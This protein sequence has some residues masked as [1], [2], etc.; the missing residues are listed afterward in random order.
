VE[1]QEQAENQQSLKGDIAYIAKTLL[2]VFG[3]FIVLPVAILVTMLA[4][5]PFPLNYLVVYSLLILIG[6]IIIIFAARIFRSYDQLLLRMKR[7]VSKVDPEYTGA[8]IAKLFD[9]VYLRFLAPA[10]R[11]W[12]IRFCGAV[13]AGVFTY[14]LVTLLIG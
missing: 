2:R 9:T 11:I 5:L 4:V 3:L 10:F 7:Q 1:P 13:I 6:V 14:L 12:W 8:E